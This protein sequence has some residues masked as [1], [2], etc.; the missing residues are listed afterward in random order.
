[1]GRESVSKDKKIEA[2]VLLKDGQSQRIV[3]KKGQRFS[4]LCWQCAEEIENR[5]I[6]DKCPWSRSKTTLN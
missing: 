2:T 5:C 3:A 4:M 1:M 6:F